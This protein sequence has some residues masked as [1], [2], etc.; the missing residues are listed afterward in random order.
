MNC[1]NGSPGEHEPLAA[2]LPLRWKS[3]ALASIVLL[4]ACGGG[5]GP[6]DM[7]MPPVQVSAAHVVER[8]VLEW[9]EF[10]G[11]VEA[12]DSIE[13]R[14][15]VA[16]YL[17]S[18][19]FREGSIVEEGDPLFTIDPREYEA[20]ATAARA[21]LERAETRL[22]LAEQELARS[23]MLIEARAIS[24]EEFDQR[25]SELQQATA[26]R[27][28]ARAEL[29]RVELNLSFARITA[30]IRGRI[31]A[32]I[33]KPGNLVTPGDTLLTTL[34]SV[35]PIYVTF[36]ADESVYLDFQAQLLD[37]GRGGERLRLPVE[38]G[39]GS[40]TGF[41][42]KGELDFIDNQLD[43]ATGTILGRAILPN[44]DGL[45]TPGL[46]ARVRLFGTREQDVLLVHDMAILTDQD[47]KYVYVVGAEN[48]AERRDIEVGGLVDG[49]RVVSAG[50][51]A[52]DRV[53]VNGV[54]RIFFPGMSLIPDTVPMDD[55]L[56][57]STALQ[58][59]GG[60]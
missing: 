3:T 49:L 21:N 45:L 18:V 5:P 60:G 41:P 16:G 51:A 24:R 35:D 53:V 56:A 25:T 17:D 44:P 28:G 37:A 11:R 39:L 14:P 1:H 23:E 10:T 34:V 42:Y 22:V 13:I 55:P 31:G 36:E 26:D 40:D 38:I 43:P 46:F 15:R 29:V 12:V 32:A 47:R 9:R 48:I 58:G 50:L 57:A 52:E 19:H 8:T 59:P 27:N 6:G 20:A 33:I 4:A 54:R 30:P 7:Q 2:K